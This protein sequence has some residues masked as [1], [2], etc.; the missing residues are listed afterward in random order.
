MRLT[1]S[2]P[3]SDNSSLAL[4]INEKTKGKENGRQTK[5]SQYLTEKLILAMAPKSVPTGGGC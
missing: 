1:A 2:A 5:D 3:N 4:K